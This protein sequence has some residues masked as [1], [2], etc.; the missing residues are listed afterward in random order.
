MRS[1]QY[2]GYALSGR[3]KDVSAEGYSSVTQ[4]AYL[5]GIDAS[6]E[7][8]CTGIQAAQIKTQIDFEIV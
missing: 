6:E 4:T 3:G 2:F 1:V 7:L 5:A 8:Y